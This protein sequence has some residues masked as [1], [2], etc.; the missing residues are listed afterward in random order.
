MLAWASTRRKQ[1]KWLLL[2]ALFLVGCASESTDL[3][4]G[5]CFI[6][7]SDGKRQL[8]KVTDVG[9]YAYVGID[10]SGVSWRTFG[11]DPKFYV[12]TDCFNSFDKVSTK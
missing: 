3:K 10:Q 7:N 12:K 8:L 4:V 1:M 6:T 2:L 5:D 9:Q 11:K